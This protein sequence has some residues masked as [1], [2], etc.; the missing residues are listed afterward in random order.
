M[1]CS[2]HVCYDNVAARTGV[3]EPLCQIRRACRTSLCRTKGST[4]QELVAAYVHPAPFEEVQRQLPR[5]NTGYIMEGMG[6][7]DNLAYRFNQTNHLSVLQQVPQ[8]RRWRYTGCFLA[9]CHNVR[10]PQYKHTSTICLQNT[11]PRGQIFHLIGWRRL[12]AWH[13]DR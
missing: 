2:T 9:A 5:C 8:Q 4:H 6:M 7:L 13:N 11:S 12:S 1:R 3:D 10:A